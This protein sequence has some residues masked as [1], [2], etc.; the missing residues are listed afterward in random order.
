MLPAT[1]ADR[2]QQGLPQTQDCGSSLPCA[3]ILIP[4]VRED[5]EWSLLF[6]RRSRTVATHQNEVSFPGGSYEPADGDLLHTALREVW[7][8]IGV[9]PK[10]ISIFGYLPATFTVT[11]FKV[12]P[13]VGVVNWPLK[14]NLS[15]DEVDSVFTIPVDW[16]S[17]E[18]NYY[19]ADY[20]SEKFGLRN[21]IH[22][23]DYK[24]EHL[25]GYTA[26]VTQQLL[27]LVK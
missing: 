23:R 26:R 8:E 13:F 19:Q 11:Q 17:D 4:L 1:L 15:T 22:Y 25:W 27:G 7:E 2:L 24:G 12:Y 18:R 6:T 14:L 16:L 20:Y 21:V 3:A 10:D 9:D 5:G